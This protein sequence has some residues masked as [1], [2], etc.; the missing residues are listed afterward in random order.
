MR[1]MPVVVMGPALE[2]SGALRRMMVGNAVGPLA[3]RRLNETL[4]FAVGLG[5]VGFGKAV[6][7]LEAPARFG[8][9]FGAECGAI[10]GEDAP[11][12]DT[13]GPKVGDGV[14]KE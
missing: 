5:S 12:A 11:H 4:G 13:Q 10:V 2:H 7:E 14:L 6:L 3:H 9:C 1:A 8:K